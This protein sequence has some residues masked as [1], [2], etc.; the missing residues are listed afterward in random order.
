MAEL[1]DRILAPIKSRRGLFVLSPTPR[2]KEADLGDAI[3]A[4]L[5]L[6]APRYLSIGLRKST[7]P[8]NRQLIVYYYQSKYQGDGFVGEST[9]QY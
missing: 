5:I 6:G 4:A 7:L 3:L 1:S 8:Q 2:H 9:F